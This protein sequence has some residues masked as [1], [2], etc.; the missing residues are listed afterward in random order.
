MKLDETSIAVGLL[1]DVLEDTL[2]TREKLDEL[3]GAE[4]AELVDGVTKICAL[5][6][7][8]EGRSSRRETFRKMILALASDLRVVLVKL[9]DR[10]HNMRTLA[11]PRPRSGAAASRRRRSR[12]T[13]RSRT[14]SAWG[15]SRASSRTSRSSYLYPQEFAEI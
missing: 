9:A 5:R 11:A 3:F 7:R 4:V 8:V 6:L 1:H 13:R 15:G 14:G 10:L 12:S 2:T